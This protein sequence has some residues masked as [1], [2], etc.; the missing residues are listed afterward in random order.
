MYMG[1]HGRKYK[2]TVK[3]FSCF[4]LK[5]FKIG[6]ITF[7]DLTI[8]LNITYLLTNFTNISNLAIWTLEKLNLNTVNCRNLVQLS[9]YVKVTIK[10]ALI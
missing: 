10:A 1:A 7:H 8:N 4:K 9:L 3:L 6:P 2:V 5:C